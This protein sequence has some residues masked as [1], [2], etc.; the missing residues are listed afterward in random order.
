MRNNVF[1]KKKSSFLPNNPVDNDNMEDYIGRI[2]GKPS[3][4][5]SLVLRQNGIKTRYYA[6]NKNQE[7]THT[8]AE[9]AANAIKKLFKNDSDLINLELLTTA[10]SIPDYV[11]PSHASM[12]HGFLPET[13]NIEIFS[14]SG[15]CL[16]SLQALKIAFLSVASG[17]KNNAVC[18][19]SELVSAALLSKHYDIEYERCHNIGENPYFGFEK[20]FLRFMLSDGAGAVYLDSV[21]NEFGNTL[22]I[23]WIEMES[24]A[25]ALPACMIAGADF[26]SDGS[27]ATWKS[28]DGYEI[29]DKSVFTVK[30]DI[31]LLK[32]H[33]INLWVNHIEKVLKNH[34]IKA[35]NINYVIPHVSSM[36]FYKELLKEIE[37]RNIDLKENKWFTNLTW[38]G[39]MGSASI[40]VALDELVRTKELKKGEKI[41]LLV[42]ESGR[43]SYGT[44]LISIS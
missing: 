35:E 31:R 39:N 1:I 18:C 28:Y 11:L 43:F 34:H 2:E 27:I 4:V 22:K 24:N 40:F 13:K 30:Q 8:S 20:D 29:S 7:I 41:L 38:V 3:R 15:V 25:N 42:P 5:R 14:T 37:N 12:V 16:T 17:E 36:F 9:M 6:L 19:A 23:E 33:I 21:P 26:N 44:A 32:K 10:T